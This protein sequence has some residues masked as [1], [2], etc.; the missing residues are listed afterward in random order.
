MGKSNLL[1]YLL[2]P[3]D[4]AF[5]D[6]FEESAKVCKQTAALFNKIVVGKLTEEHIVEAKTL[7][8]KSNDLL[9]KT[10]QKV[11]TTFVTPIDRE[12][13]QFIA[14]RLNKITKKIVKACVN[15]RVYRLEKFTPNMVKQSETLLNATDELSFVITNFKKNS[16]VPVITESNLRMKEVESHGDEILY[17]AM[18][19]L[20]SG[21]FD[22]LSVIK[23][24]DIHKD[25][26]NAL[27]SCFSVSD[28]IVNIVLKR[29]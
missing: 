8:H 16:S 29:N 3:E 5:Y 27:D 25:I 2:P 4:K 21:E 6:L 20:F 28:Q 1:T 19:R 23:M 18:D 11:N 17:M 9:K 13:I 15:L 7:K 10:L 22:A 26:E 14:V 24:R 12:D